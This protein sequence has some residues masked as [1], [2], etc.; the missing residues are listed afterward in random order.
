MFLGEIESVCYWVFD[1]LGLSC[2]SPRPCLLW[3]VEIRFNGYGEG[4]VIAT[5]RY[6]FN[7]VFWS[8]LDKRIRERV[9]RP[10]LMRSVFE[11]FH[12]SQSTRS[13]W[14]IRY[15]NP[16]DGGSLIRV[17]LLISSC[18][19]SRVDLQWSISGFQSLSLTSSLILSDSQLTLVIPKG[20]PR[21]VFDVGV[22]RISLLAPTE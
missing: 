8:S 19:R 12:I 11:T 10:T 17:N 18:N 7:W 14:S 3:Q 13:A 20:K 15:V 16:D 2:S 5:W 21:Y 1:V 9:L 4:G 6:G 22:S